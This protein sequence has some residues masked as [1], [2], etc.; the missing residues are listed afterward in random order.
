[1]RHQLSAQSELRV[2]VTRIYGQRSTERPRFTEKL[3]T[4]SCSQVIRERTQ[5][6]RAIRSAP[7]RSELRTTD[8]SKLGGQGVG[9]AW[10]CHHPTPTLAWD[11]KG[12]AMGK[13]GDRPST[14]QSVWATLGPAGVPPNSQPRAL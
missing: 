1:M 6:S 8:S 11:G 13:A 5:M 2:T 3:N 9:W 12:K 14:A 4:L 7:I 10:L